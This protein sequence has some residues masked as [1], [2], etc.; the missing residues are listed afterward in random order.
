[1]ENSTEGVLHIKNEDVA[2]LVMTPEGVVVPGPGA[3]VSGFKEEDTYATF[4]K[5]VA[6]STGVIIR[7]QE[8]GDGIN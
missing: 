3:S 2:L 6:P 4:K 8:N 7:N 1:M 5:M